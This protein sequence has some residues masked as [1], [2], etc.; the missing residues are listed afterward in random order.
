VNK[1]L[2]AAAVFG[3]PALLIVLLRPFTTW[4]DS[5]KPGLGDLMNCGFAFGLLILAAV[6]ALIARKFS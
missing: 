3:I 4:G 1:P 5:I 6:A 2:I